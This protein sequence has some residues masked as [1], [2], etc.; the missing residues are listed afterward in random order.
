MTNTQPE[1]W[2]MF[3]DYLSFFWGARLLGLIKRENRKKEIWWNQS[4]PKYF[5]IKL[6]VVIDVAIARGVARR[7]KKWKIV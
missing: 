5:L 4:K 1:G 2:I 7:V 6:V 3:N